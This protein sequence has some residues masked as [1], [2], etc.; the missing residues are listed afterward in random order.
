[1]LQQTEAYSIDRHGAP[2]QNLPVYQ[3]N[4][5]QIGVPDFICEV[6]RLP[7]DVQV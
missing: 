1:M 7:F 5:I 6:F 3:K 2:E 4:Q